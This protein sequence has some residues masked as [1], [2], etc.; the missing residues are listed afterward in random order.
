MIDLLKCE[1]EELLDYIYS[2]KRIYDEGGKETVKRFKN[3]GTNTEDYEVICVENLED[4]PECTCHDYIRE[5]LVDSNAE[6]DICAE[7]W[8]FQS[9]EMREYYQLLE[10]LY[11]QRI[12]SE[13]EYLQYHKEMIEYIRRVLVNKQYNDG[14]FYCHLDEGIESK[15]SRIEIYWYEGGSFKGFDAACGIGAVF[16]R[17]HERLKAL[18]DEYSKKEETEVNDGT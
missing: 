12:I 8:V 3:F 18:E 14:G 1:M 5:E 13:D 2:L 17:Y 4:L 7:M 15:N 6:G 9:K 10:Q 16:E 11:T